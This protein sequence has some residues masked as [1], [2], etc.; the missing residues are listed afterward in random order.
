LADKLLIS[1]DKVIILGAFKDI[2]PVP[3]GLAHPEVA[4]N[5]KAAYFPTVFGL[6]LKG[7][8]RLGHHAFTTVSVSP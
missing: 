1:A 4:L 7:F 3:E 5:E 6:T 8:T 2:F